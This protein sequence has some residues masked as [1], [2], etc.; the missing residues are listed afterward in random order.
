[1]LHVAEFRRRVMSNV[2]QLLRKGVSVVVYM[3]FRIVS[4]MVAVKVP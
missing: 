1:M 4:G 3:T 2:T